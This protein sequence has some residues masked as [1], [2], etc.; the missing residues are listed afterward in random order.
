[1]LLNGILDLLQKI[2]DFGCNK[3]K[4]NYYKYYDV[5]YQKCAFIF[6][7]CWKQGSHDQYAK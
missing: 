5:A 6:Q 1:M 4:N 3:K 7:N 2:N